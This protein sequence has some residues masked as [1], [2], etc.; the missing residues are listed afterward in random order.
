[1]A[2]GE[3]PGASE[4]PAYAYL[5]FLPEV[6]STENST[7]KL[8]RSLK[9]TYKGYS[10]MFLSTSVQDKLARVIRRGKFN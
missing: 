10:A 2:P 8:S 4:M 5:T 7:P 1:M 6:F 3:E 9:N